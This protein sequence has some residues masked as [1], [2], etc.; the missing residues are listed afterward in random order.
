MQPQL[1]V[2]AHRERPSLPQNTAAFKGKEEDA[3]SP[4]G[5]EPGWESVAA[6]YLLHHQSLM[7]SLCSSR[8]FSNGQEHAV[9]ARVKPAIWLLPP[10]A[11]WKINFLSFLF[12]N[13]LPVRMLFKWTHLKGLPLEG[14]SSL[15]LLGL[16]RRSPNLQPPRCPEHPFQAVYLLFPHLS[17]AG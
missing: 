5:A 7:L 11:F 1:V 3:F 2:S 17:T 13:S 4:Q 8:N 12:L 16:Q 9:A 6:L 14:Q 10:A 15:A